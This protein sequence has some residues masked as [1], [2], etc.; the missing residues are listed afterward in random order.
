[1]TQRWCEGRKGALGKA[2]DLKPKD[3]SFLK[4]IFLTGGEDYGT[5]TMESETAD[6]GG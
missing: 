6:E 5:Q 1:M 2:C 3:R 4:L